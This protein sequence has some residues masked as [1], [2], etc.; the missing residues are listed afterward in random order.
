MDTPDS[1]PRFEDWHH[2]HEAVADAYFPHTLEPLTA[3]AAAEASI[4]SI[5]LGACRITHMAL[6]AEV[7][8]KSEHPGAYGINIPV[9]GR[10]ETV[11]ERTEVA[12]EVGQ[13]TACP[14]GVRTLIPHWN[15]SCRLIGFKIDEH[16]LQREM[17][18]ILDRPGRSLPLQLDLR[19][20][21]GRSWLKFLRSTYDLV[22]SDD[23]LLHNDLMRIQLSAA[24]TTG[25]V[26]AAVP[27]EDPG[28]SV[29]RPRVVKRVIAA[30]HD[31]PARA[32]TPGDMA[33]IAGVSVRRL[34]Q[35]FREYVGVT[36]FAYL[37]DA[38]MERA[39]ADLAVSVPPTTVLDVILRWG[40]THPGRFAA[41]YRRKY[42]VP[43]SHTLTR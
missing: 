31:D 43:P 23:G 12:S 5:D 33:E 1:S 29:Y 37:H 8:L 36:P 22:A 3:G 4:G 9:S 11:I 6:G 15:P 10:L 30:I 28:R 20:D 2:L 19:G 40:F 26:L 42:G 32:W 39:H 27:D 41:E 7:A 13:A 21:A 38:R 24:V 16:Y 34:Q 35:A 14:P 17:D 18:R 25:F